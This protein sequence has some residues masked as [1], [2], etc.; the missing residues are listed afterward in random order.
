MPNF[1]WVHAEA[2]AFAKARKGRANA[3][4]RRNLFIATPFVVIFPGRFSPQRT[5]FAGGKVNMAPISGAGQE[6]ICGWGKIGVLFGVSYRITEVLGE[7][8]GNCSS[9][10]T[11]TG[12]TG[13]SAG[14]LR[15]LLESKGD[16]TAL[17]S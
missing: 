2:S 3:L 7:T 4:V 15:P 9:C 6:K 10:S 13:A 14:N 12:R 8:G 1:H 17:L 11:V 5:I 16:R